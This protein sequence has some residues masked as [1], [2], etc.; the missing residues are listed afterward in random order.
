MFPADQLGLCC[1]SLVQADFRGLVE[2]ASEAGFATITLWP[3]LY[4]AALEEGASPQELRRMLRDHGLSVIELDPLCTWLPIDPANAGMAGP[5]AAFGEDD[6]FRM[7]EV[8]EART[9]NVIHTTSIPVEVNE[10]VGRL[11]ALCERA[12]AHDLDV[13]IEFLPWSPIPDLKSALELAKAT[14]QGNCGV[15]I[16]VWHHFRS[17]GDLEELACVDPQWVTALQFNDVDAQPWESVIEE[18]SQGRRLPGEGCTDSAK[19]LT[20]LWK[21]GVRVPLSVEVFNAGLMGLPAVEAA[22]RIHESTQAVL[23]EASS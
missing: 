15:N 13:S 3:T 20:A 10:M 16:D 23:A 5:F 4:R 7:A 6:F 1:G 22:R 18:T 9:L 14:G 11:A 2:A 12:R 21:A 17:G 8:F 19:V